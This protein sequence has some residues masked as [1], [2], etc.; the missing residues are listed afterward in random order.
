M[1]KEI[2]AYILVSGR[3]QGVFFRKYIR[4]KAGIIGVNGFVKNLPNKKVECVF[5]GQRDRV[6]KMLKWVKKGSFFARVDNIEI[7]Y[8]KFKHKFK[9]FEIRY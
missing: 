4:K 2:R 5:E 8:E 3:V 9:N 1:E 6:E 7:K